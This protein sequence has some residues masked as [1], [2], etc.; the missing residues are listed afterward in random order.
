MA[1][2]RERG[3]SRFCL[4]HGRHL[5]N[6]SC[7]IASPPQ[8]FNDF[9]HLWPGKFQ[10]KTNGVTPRRWLA[11]CNPRLSAVITKWLGTDAWVQNLDLLEGLLPHADNADLQRE[12]TEAK[13]ANKE[14]L[15][16]WLKATTGFDVPKDAMYDVQVKRIHEYKRQLLNA[17][18]IAYR[19]KK[20]KETPAGERKAK[21]VPKVGLN[22]GGVGVMGERCVC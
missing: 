9:F 15:R 3:G 18:A 12:W 16:Q 7:H 11:W 21:F 14:S 20:I 6:P 17:L 1:E 4:L 10:N 8:V 2:G 5:R 19:Y 13:R 22:A